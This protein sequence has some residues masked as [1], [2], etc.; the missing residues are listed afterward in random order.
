VQARPKG[1]IKGISTKPIMYGGVQLNETYQRQQLEEINKPREQQLTQV[2]EESGDIKQTETIRY[3]RIPVYREKI[4]DN[5]PQV[6]QECIASAPVVTKSI[7]TPVET[8]VKSEASLKTPII[9]NQIVNSE[10]VNN[11]SQDL[12]VIW[13]Q[14]LASL[15][16]PSTRKLLSQQGELVRLDRSNAVVR[17]APVW[18]AMV[19]SRLPLLE[20]ATTKALGETRQVIIEPGNAQALDAHISKEI[21]KPAISI[22][23][24]KP[25][26]TPATP[27]S[28]QKALENNQSNGTDE[29]LATFNIYYGHQEEKSSN[30]NPGR[31]IK[32][33]E[34]IDIY[35]IK[36]TGGNFYF[37]GS[38]L[39][40]EGYH[41]EG[42]LVD[43]T[44]DIKKAHFTFED[45]SLGYWPEY[46]SLSPQCRGAYLDWLSGS[47]ND[48]DTPIGYVFIYFHGIERRVTVDSITTAVNDAEFRELFN[49]V[50]RLKDTY[51]ASHSFLH[52]STRLMEVMYILRPHVITL[53]CLGDIPQRDSLL[54]R[55]RLGSAVD[56]GDPISP[57]LALAWIY[58]Y[59]EYNLKTPARRCSEEFSQIFLQLYSKKYKDG[60]IVKP[61]KTRLK[62]NYYP[63][64]SSL[65]GLALPELNLPDPSNLKIPVN[66]IIAIAEESTA[67]LDSYSRYLGRPGSSQKDIEALL[68]LPDEICSFNADN[69]FSELKAWL[70]NTILLKDG[71]ISVKDFWT[72][73]RLP[74]PPKINKQEATLI[75]TLVQKMGYGLAPDSRFHYAKCTIEGKLVLFLNGLSSEYIPSKSYK[76]MVLALHLGAIVVNIDSVIEQPEKNILAKLIDYDINLTESEK[77]S[78]HA[79]LAWRLSSTID[80]AGVKSG[81]EKLEDKQKEVISRMLISVALADGKIHPL[82]IKQI[83]KFYIMLNL[84]KGQVAGDIHRMRTSRII[85]DDIASES[86][87]LSPKISSFQ[88]DASIIAIH[89]SETRDVQKMLSTI[90][91]SEEEVVM[92]PEDNLSAPP[93]ELE[94]GIDKSHYA[95]FETLVRK[96]KWARTE[97]EALC[98][99][100]DLMTNGALETLNEWSFDRVKAPLFEDHDD[101]VYVLQDIAKKIES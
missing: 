12:A 63:A 11:K 51:K 36:L 42:S 72:Y 90:F 38:L 92:S 43:N 34:Q 96:D 53:T 70:D 10:T 67:K 83:E 85:D 25:I 20:Q 2:R 61:N 68:L 59:P 35:D 4:K 14:I 73:L 66:K 75:E 87:L 45:D 31:W 8:G 6:E 21:T 88:L 60:V 99:D 9:N 1:I 62:I 55:Y 78:L 97:I 48:L 7:H 64:S 100:L 80:F 13:Q 3:Q 44:L 18:V 58:F 30:I 54:F 69:R 79:Y 5:K 28:I 49:E 37:G 39:A 22:P 81:L 47:R 40:L 15:E 71:M 89:E 95:L 41:T 50:M 19:Q 84:D 77:N 57:E 74:L 23:T 24:P 76:E 17:V 98:R 82:E 91:I 29:D 93:N 32:P 101:A 27:V 26:I 33:G 16:L 52:Y 56:R 65:R 94:I 46:I 86:R